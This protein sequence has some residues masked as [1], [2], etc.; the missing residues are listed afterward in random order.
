MPRARILYSV[1][2]LHHV[3]LERQAAV[4]ARPE[5]L[6]AS[7]RLAAGG[8]HGRL[9]GGRG[10]HPLGRA[11]QKLCAARCR[12][13][14]SIAC[15]GRCRSAQP[16]CRSRRAAGPGVHRQLRPCAERGR[17]ALAGRGGDAAGAAGPTR[18]SSACWWA[19]TCRR[20]C[21]AWR[22]PAWCALGQVAELGERV[23]QVRLTVAPLRYGAGVKGKVLDSLA[24]GVP[25]IM[26]PVAA[27][28]LELPD[29]LLALVSEDA[30]ALAAL[31]CRLHRDADGPS[32]GGARRTGADPRR[33]T[34]QTPSPRH[35]RRR[36]RGGCCRYRGQ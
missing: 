21:G 34:P 16:R 26:S 23:R 36:S 25:C 14:A 7:R 12:R 1:A 19:A 30:A 33:T 13:P 29:S 24:A 22:G 3:R 17:G 2:D 32:P 31:I 18:T 35:C 15:R 6:A 9:V 27:E 28:G 5:L 4:E 11:R 10:D 8:V 20:R